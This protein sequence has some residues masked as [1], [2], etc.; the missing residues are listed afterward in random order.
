MLIS[1][2]SIAVRKDSCIPSLIPSG[3]VL[4]SSISV[5]SGRSGR[6]GRRISSPSSREISSPS[7]LH[8]LICQ[9]SFKSDTS[10]EPMDASPDNLGSKQANNIEKKIPEI[11]KIRTPSSILYQMCMHFSMRSDRVNRLSIR[12][13]HN[14]LH[15]NPTIS[16]THN[17]TI[18]F[19]QFQSSP[20]T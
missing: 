18:N 6:Q 13:P 2:S 1:T 11:T 3:K 20:L 12:K 19:R 16:C 7:A 5:P 14:S 10:K 4:V 9:P 17:N 8:A 15:T